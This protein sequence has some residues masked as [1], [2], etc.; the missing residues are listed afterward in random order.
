VFAWITKHMKWPRP[1]L[2]LGFILGKILERYMFISIER[3]G[4]TWMQRPVVIVLF[5]M[6]AL[7]LVRPLLKE[8]KAHGGWV[9]MVSDFHRPVFHPQQLYPAGLLV[10][11]VI[12][13]TEAV[14]WNYKAAIIP[15][16]V[17]S[18]AILFCS[19]SLINDL[20]KSQTHAAR[21]EERAS[22]GIAEESMHLDI[23]SSID[24]LPVKTLIL[25]AG[26]FFGW[27]IA[28][29]CSMATIG[30]IPTIPLFIII[31]M[32]V[33]GN[34]RWTVTLGMALFMTLLV[35][36]VFDQLL[37]IPWPS[38]IVGDHWPWWHDHIPSG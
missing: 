13:M 37:T 24:H 21:K 14:T 6:A 30:L 2:V 38:T 20:F 9:G 15:L 18:G 1:P 26:I 33:E 11:F 12:M 5:A 35:Y 22:K 29:M 3:Y 10:I 32:K 31:F 28:F 17:G 23:A 16:I 25:R 8:V 4:V 7:T 34:E 36:V 27:M 19:L